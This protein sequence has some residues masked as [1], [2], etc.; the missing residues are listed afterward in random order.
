M[1]TSL[2]MEQ[3]K[4]LC[5]ISHETID[6]AILGSLLSKSDIIVERAPSAQE[7]LDLVRH[8][9][10]DVIL[11]DVLLAPGAPMSDAQL[12]ATWDSFASEP[13]AYGEMGLYFIKMARQPPSLN[14][15]T[16]IVV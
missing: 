9:K 3:K 6:E 13:H 1:P 12:R 16:P 2:L 10:Y 11:T 15:E 5:T 8:F 7:A 14:L 4:V